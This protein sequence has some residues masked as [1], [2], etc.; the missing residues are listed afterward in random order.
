MNCGHRVHFISPLFGIRPSDESAQT[1]ALLEGLV[2]IYLVDFKY[3]NPVTAQ[4]LSHASDYVEVALATRS[5][6]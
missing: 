5:S 3:S 4:R 2:D 6:R 1:L